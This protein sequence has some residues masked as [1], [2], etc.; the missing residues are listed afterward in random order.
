M[1]KP[2]VPVLSINPVAFR[3]SNATIN[4]LRNEAIAALTHEEIFINR[5]ERLLSWALISMI[6]AHARAFQQEMI[7]LRQELRPVFP[8]LSSGGEV[9][10]GIESGNSRALALAVERLSELGSQNERAMGA[11]FTIS[12]QSKVS[13]A[14]KSRRFWQSLKSAEKLAERIHSWR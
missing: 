5:Y 6:H 12:N 14:F 3:K 7:S 9:N 8:D 4:M 13:L 1:I 2:L 11:S 10:E